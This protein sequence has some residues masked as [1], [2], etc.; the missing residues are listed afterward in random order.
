MKL[1][2]VWTSS[3]NQHVHKSRF[4]LSKSNDRLAISITQ[5]YIKVSLHK[6]FLQL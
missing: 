4:H 6:N 2:A 5:W 3:E 1:A